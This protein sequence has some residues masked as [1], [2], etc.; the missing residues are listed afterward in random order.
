MAKRETRNL[1]AEVENNVR[2]GGRYESLKQ[3]NVIA[4]AKV[5]PLLREYEGTRDESGLVSA[6]GYGK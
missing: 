3:S 4:W 5:G 1:G 2:A 6:L